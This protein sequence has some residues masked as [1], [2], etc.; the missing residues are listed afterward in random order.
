MS[1]ERKVRRLQAKFQKEDEQTTLDAIRLL[2]ASATGRRFLWLQL[3]ELHVFYNPFA[4]NALQTA[5]NCGE[6]NVGQRLLAKITE[7]DPDAFLV[8]MKENQNVQRS[9]TASTDALTGPDSDAG[10]DAYT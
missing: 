7:A 3:S 10:P 9:R 5:F 1:E 4:T 6:L 8:M 2:M